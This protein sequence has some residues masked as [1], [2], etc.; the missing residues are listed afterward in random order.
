M[1][2]RSGITKSS[3]VNWGKLHKQDDIPDPSLSNF[4]F[5]PTGLIGKHIQTQTTSHF[6]MI[7][8]HVITNSHLDY[9]QSILTSLPVSTF[10]FCEVYTQP[11]C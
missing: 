5:S 4:T 6:V 9:S 11:R 7:V 8:L 3:G 2:Y 10:V 1:L